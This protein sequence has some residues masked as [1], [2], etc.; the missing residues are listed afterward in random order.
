MPNI[1]SK[2]H[3]RESSYEAIARKA[4]LP[5]EEIKEA[6]KQIKGRTYSHITSSKIV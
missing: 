1:K 3:D 4:G 5:E 2:R 6:V